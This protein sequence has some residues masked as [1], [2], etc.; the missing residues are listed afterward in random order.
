M[1]DGVAKAWLAKYGGVAAVQEV[2]TAG[3]MELWY[4]ARVRAEFHGANGAA[5]RT[6]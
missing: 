1:S 6:G 3:H 2:P 5:L 4:G